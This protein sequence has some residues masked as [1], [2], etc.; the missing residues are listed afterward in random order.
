MNKLTRSTLVALL[1]TAGLGLSSG[2][3]AQS[4]TYQSERAVCG[5]NQQDKAACLREAGAAQQAARKGALTDPSPEQLMQNALARCDRQP[6]SERRA[7]Q[8]RVRGTGQTTMDGSVM[9]GGVIRETVTPVPAGMAPA[10][11]STMPPSTMPSSTMPSSTM[12]SSNMRSA[13][14]PPQ[15]APQPVMPRS[16]MPHTMPSTTMPPSPAMPSTVPPAPATMPPR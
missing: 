5:H 10:R 12:P 15:A 2:A 1:A 13:P 8:D 4:S 3:F 9:G 14:I 11:T 16:T 6:E 7:C